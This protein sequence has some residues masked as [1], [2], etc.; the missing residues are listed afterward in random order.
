M[1]NDADREPPTTVA[2]TMDNEQRIDSGT[3]LPLERR[4]VC[5]KPTA[6]RLSDVAAAYR[7]H[8]SQNESSGDSSAHLGGDISFTQ[9]PV[10]EGSHNEQ[11][12]NKELKMGPKKH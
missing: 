9:L 10:G 7:G 4:R 6:L 3:P 2:A 5:H 1:A 8:N 12:K 11:N